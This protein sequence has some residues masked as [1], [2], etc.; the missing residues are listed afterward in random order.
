MLL[1]PDPQFFFQTSGSVH[2]ADLDMQNANLQS[3]MTTSFNQNGQPNFEILKQINVTLIQ[4]LNINIIQ[5]I[6]LIKI[7]KKF[8]IKIEL[9][10]KII[11][12]IYAI[13]KIKSN[14]FIYK[15]LKILYYSLFDF[16]KKNI[17]K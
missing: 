10:H 13:L 16:Q 8:K 2:G 7:F 17:K 12:L 4:K 9:K 15:I 6:I 5:Y 14:H 3:K 1:K 11:L